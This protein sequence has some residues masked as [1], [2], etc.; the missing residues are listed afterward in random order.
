[1]HGT[2]M[3]VLEKQAELMQIPLK[4]IAVPE[5]ADMEIYNKT[6]E[7]KLKFFSEKGINTYAFGD[8]F[9]TD[10]RAY[11]EPRLRPYLL[12]PSKTERRR[13]ARRR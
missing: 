13:N 4:K 12:G 6:L 7:N 3:E 2:R 11:R 9:L 8:I 5:N 10:L 1:M